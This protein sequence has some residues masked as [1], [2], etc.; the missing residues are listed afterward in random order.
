MQQKNIKLSI[1]V[2]FFVSVF[3][4]YKDASEASYV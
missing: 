3:E 1:S 4:N 2:R